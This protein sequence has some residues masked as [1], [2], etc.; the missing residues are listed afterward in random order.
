MH[1]S[2]SA[3]DL[4]KER[5]SKKSDQH[6]VSESRPKQPEVPNMLDVLKDMS[7]VKLRSVKKYVRL[8]REI[9]LVSV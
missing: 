8:S 1:R 4:I 9:V 7:K 2:I 5:R 3:I 6:T